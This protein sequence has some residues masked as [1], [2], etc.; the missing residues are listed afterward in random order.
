LVTDQV[1]LEEPAGSSATAY[2]VIKP[3]HSFGYHNEE[4]S[5]QVSMQPVYADDFSKKGEITT[6]TFLVESRGFSTPGFEMILF[7]SAVGAI[8]IVLS[9]YRKRM[10]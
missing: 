6:Q 7:L 8:M 1:V 9:F 4:A 10:G 5:I 3:S 2:L